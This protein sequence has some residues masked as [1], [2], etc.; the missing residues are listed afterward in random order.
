MR[1]VHFTSMIDIFMRITFFCFAMQPKEL[2]GFLLLLNQ[3]ICK[4]NTGVQDILEE[5]Y[6]AIASRVFNI[7]PR[8]AFPTGPGSNTE[9]C[10]P[11]LCM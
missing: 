7:L 10:E 4:F 1:G 11:I 5:V 9:V 3:L 6:P 8:D 2:A